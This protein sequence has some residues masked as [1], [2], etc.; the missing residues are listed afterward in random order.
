MCAA[1]FIGGLK[2]CLIVWTFR[3][4]ENG[5]ADGPL[6]LGK[7]EA[8]VRGSSGVGAGSQGEDAVRYVELL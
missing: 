1:F 5:V 4:L 2:G 3:A 6:V 8:N 7:L